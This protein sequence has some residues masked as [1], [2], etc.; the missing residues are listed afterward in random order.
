MPIKPVPDG[1]ATVTPMLIAEKAD[2]LLKFIQAA[3]DTK[4]VVDLTN[5]DGTL[6]ASDITL[7]N[8]SVTVC[9]AGKDMPAY[10]AVLY[11]YV[12]DADAAYKRGI[13]AGA[14]EPAGA[15]G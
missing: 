6:M 12:P 10:K 1:Y 15:E 13:A 11:L 4:E 3:F 14:K 8:G 9:G 7:G 2:E 5:K